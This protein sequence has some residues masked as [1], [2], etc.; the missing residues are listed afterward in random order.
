[1]SI[2]NNIRAGKARGGEECFACERGLA[3]G[4]PAIWFVFEVPALITTITVNRAAH[5]GCA[6]HFYRILGKRIKDARGK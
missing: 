5:L 4:E 1:M 2:D 3:N 6:D